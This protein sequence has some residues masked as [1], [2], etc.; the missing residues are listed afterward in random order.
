MP[1]V[2]F[3]C[4]IEAS[5]ERVWQFHNSIDTL[6][7]L[8]PPHTKARLGNEAKPMAQGIVYRLILRRGG[9]PLPAW[10]AEIIVYDPPN[11][12]TDRQVS[13]TG[14]FKE[15]THEHLF[16]AVSPSRT[17]IR[18]RITYTPPFGFLG[19]IADALFV[20]RDLSRMFAYRYQVTRTIL[21][22]AKSPQ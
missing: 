14:P 1:T 15:W 18:D 4:E 8:T 7:K 13:G 6:F 19:K 21:E 17:R 11:G 3:D 22:Q 9:I 5:L 12:F 16:E 20:R 10:D 2:E